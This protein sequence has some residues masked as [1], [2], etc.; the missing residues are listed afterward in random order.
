MLEKQVNYYYLFLLRLVLRTVIYCNVIEL[1]TN[2]LKD[3]HSLI[4]ITTY[5]LILT[6]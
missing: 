3:L 1:S 5:Y 6:M 4:I 2:K